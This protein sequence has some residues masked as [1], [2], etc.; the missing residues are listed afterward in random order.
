MM[1][2]EI[3][4]Y[5]KYIY[6][7]FL[8]LSAILLIFAAI[9]YQKFVF[10]GILYGLIGG[11]QAI[12]SALALLRLPSSSKELKEIGK[13]GIQHAWTITSIG[14]A[15]AALFL[16]PFFDISSPIITY[17]TFIIS[18]I[19]LILGAFTLYKTKK[20]TGQFLSI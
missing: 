9:S 1:N 10:T 4:K 20:D 5:L 6:L 14:L 11:I 2:M 18:I 7:A 12:I 19:Y 17:T 3:R 16:A 13:V 8:A 15:G